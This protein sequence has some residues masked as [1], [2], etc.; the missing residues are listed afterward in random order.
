MERSLVMNCGAPLTRPIRAYMR[1]LFIM[2]AVYLVLLFAVI[3]I[4]QRPQPPT[5]MLAVAVA[6]LPALP[7]IGMFWTIARLL[8]ETDDEYQRML[9]A[10]QILIATALTLSIATIWGFLENFGQ[11]PHVPAF[12]ASILWFAMLAVG[13]ALARWRA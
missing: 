3:M 10:K 7:I 6:A 9:F 13:G 11:A 12:Y 2:L 5:G 1:R 4:F 8:I